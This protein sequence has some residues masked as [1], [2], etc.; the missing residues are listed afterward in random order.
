MVYAGLI[1]LLSVGSILLLYHEILAGVSAVVATGTRASS[2]NVLADL[3]AARSREVISISLLIIAAT[4]V[5]GYLVARLALAPARSALSS[6]KEF[7]GNIAHELRTPLAIIKANTE[8]LLLE[9]P[10]EKNVRTTLVSNVEE[11]DRMSDIINNLLSLNVL[12]QPE[13]L[14]FAQV[15]LG[16]IIRRVV[17]KLSQPADKKKVRIKVHIAATCSVWGNATALEQIVTNILKNAM[18]HTTAGE[19]VITA[20]QDAQEGLEFSVRD[21]GTGITHEDLLRIL[22]PFYRGD[23]ARTRSGGVGS[24]L[25]LAI[26]NEL[27]KLHKGRISIRSAP[28]LGT[29]VTITLPH[30]TSTS[31]KTLRR[32]GLSEIFADFRSGRRHT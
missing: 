14:A 22:E 8:I 17:D 11:L 6:Q 10:R 2:A 29:T 27:V 3:E 9:Q 1:L 30:G 21:T 5:F 31:K 23:R 16:P 32:E 7:I 26:V 20:G 18:Q 25:G 13:R 28:K 15:D 12:V 4:A 19:I 24:G